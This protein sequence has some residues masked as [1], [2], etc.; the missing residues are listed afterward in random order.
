[1]S[2][3]KWSDVLDGG[4]PA[5]EPPAGFADRVLSRLAVPA[6]QLRVVADSE[7]PPR[8]AWR[9]SVLFAAVAVAA[10]VIVPLAVQRH[11]TPAHA[12]T[13]LAAGVSPDLGLERD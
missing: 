12:A 6:P 9:S 11:T 2:H 4:W 3:S 5:A 1:M 10:L 8:R 13:T 7:R